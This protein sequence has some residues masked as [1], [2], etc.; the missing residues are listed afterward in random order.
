ME[1][2]I[3]IG[4]QAWSFDEWVGPFYPLGTRPADYL[5]VY[6]RAFNSVEV[7]STFYAIPPA[8]T[9]RGWRDKTPAQFSFALKLPQEITHE[10]R[11]RDSTDIVELFADRAR[12]LGDKLGPVLIQLGPDFGPVEL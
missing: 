6:S 1:P 3:H 4:T 10:R 8:S 2:R 7:D 12:E 11:L 9:V 5:T